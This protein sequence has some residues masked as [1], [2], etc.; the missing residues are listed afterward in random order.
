MSVF[1]KPCLRNVAQIPSELFVVVLLLSKISDLWFHTNDIR[2]VKF[3]YSS[4]TYYYQ[5][6]PMHVF[7]TA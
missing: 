5:D 4:N 1:E 7:V 6:Y 3:F 2:P